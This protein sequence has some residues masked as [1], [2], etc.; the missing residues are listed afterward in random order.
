MCART[1]TPRTPIRM[2]YT[3]NS[4]WKW[5]VYIKLI[6]RLSRVK[7]NKAEKKTTFE[8]E[9]RKKSR[10]FN[11]STHRRNNTFRSSN[12]WMAN[13]RERKNTHNTHRRQR[14]RRRPWRQK[15]YNDIPE[16]SNQIF[17]WMCTF[18][19]RPTNNQTEQKH[20]LK[21]ICSARAERNHRRHRGKSAYTRYVLNGIQV[22]GV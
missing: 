6:A 3:N 11:F 2:A 7:S 20:H 17:R 18:K 15:N 9:E 4:E 13:R 8:K 12:I 16:K 22:F 14:Q 10:R 1:L 19:A 21:M 5:M